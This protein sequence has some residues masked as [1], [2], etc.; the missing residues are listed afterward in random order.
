MANEGHALLSWKATDDDSEYQ[1][2]Q[3]V[4][5]NRGGQPDFTQ[6]VIRY[7]GPDIAYFISGLPE[8]THYFRV[9][10]VGSSQWSQPL[11]VVVNYPAAGRVIVLLTLG[12]V[13]FASL[14]AIICYGHWSRRTD[15]ESSA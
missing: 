1:L 15:Q 5:E 2:E 13:L 6:T 7:Q 8:G 12:A 3:A 4:G 11:A 10:A 9:S 14:T